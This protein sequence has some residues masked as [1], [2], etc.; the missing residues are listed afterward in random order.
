MVLTAKFSIQLDMILSQYGIM[1]LPIPRHKSPTT[2][3]A[4]MQT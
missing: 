1:L 2:P 3:N 4:D